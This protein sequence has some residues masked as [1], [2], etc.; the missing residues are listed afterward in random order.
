MKIIL[1][2]IFILFVLPASFSQ[3]I[4]INTSNP[5][6]ELDIRTLS[7]NDGS[8]INIGNLD[9]SHFLRLFSG[10]DSIFPYP[11]M[12]WNKGDSLSMGTWGVNYEELLQLKSDG[13]M[14]LNSAQG[15]SLNEGNLPLI[16]RGYDPFTSGSYQGIGRW[17]VFMEPFYL[18]FGTPNIPGRG[19]QFVQY[20]SDGSI[21]STGMR[22]KD[23]NLG[24]G[25]L[26][27]L[28][29]IDAQAPQAV[30][31]LISSN[32]Q[33][34]SVLELRNTSFTDESD[35]I[36]AIN[37]SN[38]AGL[39]PGQIGYTHE[40]SM[41]FQA[42]GLERLRLHYVQ[43]FI[44]IN[45]NNPQYRLDVNGDINA[46]GAIRISGDSG[47]PGQVLTSNGAAS[48]SWL[49]YTQNPKIG[50]SATLE[51]N[52]FTTSGVNND[53]IGFDE[54]FDDGGDNFNPVL[55]EFTAPSDGLYYFE[56]NTVWGSANATA[57]SDVPIRLNM[58]VGVNAATVAGTD[59]IIQILNTGYWDSVDFTHLIKLNEGEFVHFKAAQFSGSTVVLLGGTTTR[60]RISGYKVY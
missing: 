6:T 33:N 48:P 14:Y 18:T 39:V 3:F 50:F 7:T 1:P 19:F 45:Q 12:Y 17:G 42:G 30:A 44:G 10:R 56:V 55:G 13:T 52:N 40:G 53:L 22:L 4:G 49:T 23:G 36:G 41:I 32:T 43:G 58:Y 26:D 28:Y 21:Q 51:S 8:I 11:I 15:I 38:P 54:D 37:F 35:Y 9:N 34:G 27:P 29:R 60:T 31:R 2:F 16:T 5:Q 59:N 20:N 25:T 46:A 24:I 57:L 47:T